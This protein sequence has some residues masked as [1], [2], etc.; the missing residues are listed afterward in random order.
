MTNPEIV[1]SYSTLTYL[2]CQTSIR[3]LGYAG[4]RQGMPEYARVRQGMPEFARIC[5]KKI[6]L[7]N[8]ESQTFYNETFNKITQF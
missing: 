5:Q 8:N 3:T 7:N 6:K 4:V 1:Y 2:V